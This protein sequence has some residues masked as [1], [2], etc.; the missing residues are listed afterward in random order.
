MNK[1]ILKT[2]EDDVWWKLNF[3]QHI[4][5]TSWPNHCN[6]LDST[7]LYDEQNRL[8]RFKRGLSKNLRN[9]QELR[10]SGSE[11]IKKFCPQSL[12]VT[13]E[14]WY[15]ERELFALPT[16]MILTYLHE[17]GEKITLIVI[18]RKLKIF[19]TI[20]CSSFPLR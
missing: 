5:A 9:Q 11:R 2:V 18:I 13:L 16:I 12:G 3:L 10:D 15:I 7:M 14:F 17:T 20:E 8:Q 4:H 19:L 6:Q 1:E